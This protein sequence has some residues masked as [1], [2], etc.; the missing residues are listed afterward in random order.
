MA[1]DL[2]KKIV[3]R[4]A[5]LLAA[6]AIGSDGNGTDG[7]MGYLKWLANDHPKYYVNLLARV[8]PLHMTV[9]HEKRELRTPEEIAASLR[10]KGIPVPDSLFGDTYGQPQGNVIS[11]HPNK[12][13]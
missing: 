1:Y 2:S 6:E 5:I 7:L 11:L 4:D 8:V 9:E 3:L 12:I 13:N 10:S